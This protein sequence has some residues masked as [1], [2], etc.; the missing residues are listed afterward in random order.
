LDWLNI[1]EVTSTD[2]GRVEEL[3]RFGSEHDC[4]AFNLILFAQSFVLPCLQLAIVDVGCFIAEA[5]E[6]V[7]VFYSAQ[8][9]VDYEE[10]TISIHE[11]QVFIGVESHKRPLSL[12]RDAFD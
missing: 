4:I 8:E 2:V 1:F 10:A 11:H 3:L 7:L 12:S 5:K 6:G 9:S